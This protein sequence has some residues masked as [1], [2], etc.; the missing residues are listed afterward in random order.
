MNEI[1]PV[2]DQ[3]QLTANFLSQYI[4]LNE[5]GMAIPPEAEVIKQCIELLLDEKV[6]TVDEIRMEA[7][8]DFDVIIP[9]SLFPDKK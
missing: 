1:Q 5:G 6:M 2:N 4:R 8:R 3:L 9:W 7:L